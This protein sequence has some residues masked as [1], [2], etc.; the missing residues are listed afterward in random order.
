MKS[1]LGKK[2]NRSTF[3]RP[4]FLQYW[5]YGE[6]SDLSEAGEKLSICSCLRGST[7]VDL[8]RGMPWWNDRVL[9]AAEEE[10]KPSINVLESFELLQKSSPS[11]PDLSCLFPKPDP[12][13]VW[14]GDPFSWPETD[15]SNR[16]PRSMKM[17]AEADRKEL[18]THFRGFSHGK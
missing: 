5:R 8:K 9:A 12:S 2:K 11:K 1:N 16:T 10:E 18:S 14:P 7:E 4:E 13:S 17:D 3:F 6:T 15:P